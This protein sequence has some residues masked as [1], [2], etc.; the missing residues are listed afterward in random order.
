MTLCV[1]CAGATVLGVCVYC[2][3]LLFQPASISTSTRVGGL[4]VAA[5]P[6]CRFYQLVTHLP[7]AG[8]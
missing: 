6:L 7:A 4:S 5:S 3:T 8:I 2:L 1:V